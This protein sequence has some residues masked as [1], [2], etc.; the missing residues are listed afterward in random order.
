MI[1]RINAIAAILPFKPTVEDLSNLEIAYSPPFTA[2]I[3]IINAAG[4]TAENILSGLNRPME[5]G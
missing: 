5:P 1:G 2:A 3:D 4:N